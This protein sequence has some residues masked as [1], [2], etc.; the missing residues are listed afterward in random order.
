MKKQP[1]PIRRVGGSL[2]VRVPPELIRANDLKVGD[3]L[4]F[5][6]DTEVIKNDVINAALNAIVG[7]KLELA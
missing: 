7:E 4:V 5:G 6:A 2:Y 3:C 1:I